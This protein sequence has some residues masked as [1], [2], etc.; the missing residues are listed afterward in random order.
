MLVSLEWLAELVELNISP[1][2]LADRFALSGL[3][4]ES[5]TTVGSDT[6][7]DLEVTSNRGDLLGHIGIAREAAV[8]LGNP[9]KLPALKM[10]LAKLTAANTTDSLQVT[11]EMPDGCQ[12]YTARVV[13]GIRVGPSPEWLVNRLKSVNVASVNNV[14]DATNYVM[15]ECGQPLHAFDLAKINGGKIVVRAGAAKE[16]FTAI[17]H[18]VYELDPHTVVIAD[19]SGPLAIAG[20]MGGADSEI[21]AATTDVVIEAALFTP[22]FVRRTARRLKLHSPS[23]YRFERR[24]DPLNVDWAAARCCELIAEIAGGKISD[25]RF[26]SEP[27]KHVNAEVTLRHSQVERVLGAA[28]PAD[29]FVSILTA[30]GCEPIASPSKA[31]GGDATTFVIPSFRGDLPREID[32]IEEIVRIDG[33]DNISEHAIVPTF[34]SQKRDKDVLLDRVRTVLVGCGYCEVLTPS[35]V[36]ENL[37]DL[38]SPW[39]ERPTLRTMMPMLEGASILRQSLLPSLLA[40]RL[41]NQSLHNEPANLFEIAAIYLA[42]AESSEVVEPPVIGFVTSDDYRMARGMVEEIIYRCNRDAVCKW[43]AWD[44][45]ATEPGTGMQL[46]LGG[47]PLGWFGAIATKVKSK[48]KLQGNLVGGELNVAVLMASLQV[49]PTLKP[50]NTNPAIERDFNFVV[51]EP[52]AWNELEQVVREINEPLL[53]DVR[54]KET[55][56][57]AKRDGADKKRVLISVLMQ[58]ESQTLTSEAADS[59]STRIVQAVERKV[60]GRLLGES[61]GAS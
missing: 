24:V 57:D 2:E 40:T 43:E 36:R 15:M 21:T 48:L 33:Y 27:V 60:G 31:S 53:Q 16:Q 9:L 30:L 58:A 17:D 3:N 18:K 29:R 25:G 5:T 4:H 37:A 59:I 46:S 11:N 35:C 14:V 55:Y 1:E 20:I 6:V 47:Q 23:S 34:V 41:T 61:D 22:L 26:E 13:R 39:G 7:L 10:D 12:R 50:I 52:L 45:A 56:R 42:N 44:N 49:L 8:L 19:S 32:L 28:I 54:Y 38:M 51:P